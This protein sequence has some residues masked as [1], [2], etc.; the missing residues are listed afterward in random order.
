MKA[1]IFTDGGEAFIPEETRSEGKR[2]IG[3]YQ[4]GSEMRKK[5]EK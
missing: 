2:N 3:W 1:P 4:N 5:P